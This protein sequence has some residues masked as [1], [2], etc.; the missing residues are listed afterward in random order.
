[1]KSTKYIFSI[2]ILTLILSQSGI[3]GAA[4]IQR[5]QNETKYISGKIIPEVF[6]RSVPSVMAVGEHYVVLVPIENTGS[7][8]VD[9]NVI[10]Y[11]NWKYFF[12]EEPSKNIT[13]SGGEKRILR[14]DAVP[15]NKHTGPLQITAKLFVRSNGDKIKELDVASDSVTEIKKRDLPGTLFCIALGIALL[16]V[17]LIIKLTK[18]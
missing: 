18:G 15:Y 1:M 4:P 10:L 5:E 14:F 9:F 11:Y 6:Q 17:L 3:S 12:F 2:A 16:T 7:D 13:L 8:A